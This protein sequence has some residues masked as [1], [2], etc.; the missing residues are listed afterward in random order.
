MALYHFSAKVLS[1]S[2][3]NTV[4]AVAYRAGCKLYD[5][6]TGQS[7]DYRSKAVEHVELM[8]PK[9]APEWAL[10]MQELM[11][12]DRQKGVQALCAIVEGAEK[13]M[14]AQVWREFEFALQRELTKEQNVTLARE[15]IQDQICARGMAAQL[16]FHF[17]VDEKTGEDKPHCH[18]LITLRPL[19]KE[20]LSPKKE[21]AWNSQE[22]LTQMRVQ[23]QDYGN[24][25]LK[26]HGH[27]VRIDHRSH[28]ERGL[29]IEPQPKMGKNVLELEKRLQR[30]EG[31]ENKDY[32]H[33]HKPEPITDKAKAF[34]NT[35]LRNLYRIM[36]RPDIVFEIV[37]KHHSTF[38][39]ADMQKV[40]N[41]YVDDLPL[42]QRLEAKLQNSSELMLLKS[43]SDGQSIY[44]T[45]SL[46]KT[47]KALVETAEI[48]NRSKSH[49]VRDDRIDW[50]IKNADDIL[51]DHGGLSEDQKNAISHMVDE[52]QIKCVVGIAGAGKTTALGVCHHI[53]KT[54]GY[55]V[56]GL[57]PT[58]KAAHNLE[59]SKISSQ[60]LHKFLKSYEEGRCQY[61]PNSVLVLDEAG[62]VDMERFEK[63]LGAVQ[64]LGVKLVIVGDGAQ[65]QPVE[66]GPAFRLV[67]QRLGK[68]EL[69]TVLRQKEEWQREATVLFGRQETQTAIQKYVDKGY[70]HIIEEKPF[71]AYASFHDARNAGDH[72]A[73]VNF[74]EISTRQSSRIFREMAKACPSE[75]SQREAHSFIRGHQDYE[76]YQKWKDLQ[77]ST[78]A[79]ILS[80]GESYRLSLGKQGIDPTQMAFLFVNKDLGKEAQKEAVTNLLKEKGLDSLV[81]I[82]KQPDQS[83]DMRKDAKE[84]LTQAWYSDFKV[85]PEK[86]SL[87][88]AYSNRDVNDLNAS[89]RALLKES[90]HI[91]KEEYT[92]TI[93]KMAENDFGDKH[94][95]KE[96]KGFSKG[97]RIVFTRNNYGLDV[98]NGTMGTITN[99]DKQTIHARLDGKENKEISFAPNLNPHFNQGWA[100]TIHKSQGTTV[101]QTYVLASYEMNQ[102]LAYVAMTRHRDNVQ[103]FGSN[104]DFWRP[105][106]LPEGLAK[107]GEKLS[108]ADYLDM[109]AL[110][111]LMQKEDHL[112]TKIFERVSNELEAMG[113]VSKKAFWQAA[114]Y[115]LGANRDKEMRVDPG[116]SKEAVREEVRAE[117]L[118][119]TKGEVVQ[120][121]P[122]LRRIE[123]TKAEFSNGYVERSQQTETES[124]E[125]SVE[126]NFSKLMW[127]CEQR[128]YENLKY[129][130]MTLTPT[131]THRIPIQAERT[132][133]FILHAYGDISTLPRESEMVNFSLRAKYELD[134]IPE[135]QKD[136][137]DQGETNPYR[138]YHLADRLAS[139]EGR[140]DFEAR[141]KGTEALYP[142]YDAKKELIKHREELPQLAKDLSN[143]YFLP[144]TTSSHFAQDILRYRETHGEN[145]SANQLE[146]MVQ[147]AQRVEEKDYRRHF[148]ANDSAEK[149]FL[150]SREREL[151]FRHGLDYDASRNLDQSK[152]QVNKSLEHIQK[153]MERDREHSKEMDFSL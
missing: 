64:Q 103:V 51:K 138:T 147:I 97:D 21:R 76:S 151:L 39:W 134:R 7:F 58:G 152:S 67:T 43:N 116:F 29:D 136:L 89:A 122:C 59:Q 106:K 133:A 69:N 1:R 46:L 33:N 115:F 125:T 150:H 72:E 17:D 124:L 70:V 68:V 112:L 118:L 37:S 102:N 85:Q 105:E 98:K 94:T 65:L 16:N 52:G 20:G 100:V 30:L 104:L 74:Y 153:Q 135:I 83:I 86:Q 41:R 28:Q 48:L 99:L 82:E 114:D 25:H 95:V 15:F 87:M 27:D 23:W 101:D 31:N 78:A 141:L 80:K 2:T 63:L 127:L 117:D 35:Q 75:A 49:G 38:M 139:I 10:E 110:N 44:T 36:R 144:Q 53:W 12:E 146:K 55:A 88:L 128:L 61:N 5:E 96:E 73:I 14:D 66:A 130:K 149:D 3:R 19:T 42:F 8:L 119:K 129:H 6:K 91:S 92:Y 77:K 26:L 113:A 131:R 84:A 45:R 9:D 79:E 109:D 54:E 123:A 34:H 121:E 62:M 32:E 140:L 18:A 142:S 120:K 22:F 111:K 47:E 13:R 57:A 11:K 90:G 50:V 107:S 145:P 132:A 126:T 93:A 40:L 148:Y 4:G 137:M 108:A 71:G 24:F 143:R 81:G 60:T 56:Y